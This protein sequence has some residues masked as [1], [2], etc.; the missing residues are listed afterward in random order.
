MKDGAPDAID[1]FDVPVVEQQEVNAVT[2][3]TEDVIEFQCASSELD[4]ETSF[5]TLVYSS[6]SPEPDDLATE[7]NSANVD[8]IDLAESVAL[9]IQN[10]G[11][12][13]ARRHSFQ[14][15]GKIIISRYKLPKSIFSPFII[16][17]APMKMQIQRQYQIKEKVYLPLFVDLKLS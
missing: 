15:E 8:G 3:Q 11:K 17:S 4:G 2:S 13:L 7:S 12:I 9:G 6:S 10:L 1:D 14:S 5:D 16:L